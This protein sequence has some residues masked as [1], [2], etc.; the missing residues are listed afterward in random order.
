MGE[1]LIKQRDF[2]SGFLFSA[3]RS[4]GPGGQHVNKVS[5]KVELRFDVEHSE[6]LSEEERET[7]TKKLSGKISKDGFLILTSQSERTQAQN[8]EKVVEKFYALIRKAFQPRKKRTPTS[9]TKK[10]VEERLENKR[11][12]SEK[13]RRRKEV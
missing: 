5:T 2:S 1:D 10:S 7:L 8:K 4:S 11:L 3:S 13:K 12:V 9:P 6:L